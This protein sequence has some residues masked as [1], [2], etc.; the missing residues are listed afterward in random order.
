MLHKYFNYNLLQTISM[1]AFFVYKN[2]VYSYYKRTESSV[3]QLRLL[4]NFTLVY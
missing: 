1:S 3:N 2:K 4:P